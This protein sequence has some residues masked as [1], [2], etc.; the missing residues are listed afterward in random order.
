MVLHRFDL[1]RLRTPIHNRDA[2]QVVDLVLPDRGLLSF[3]VVN[4]FLPVQ[5]PVL[6]RD[7]PKPAND[8]SQA[9]QAQAPLL[10]F[11]GA[12]GFEDL[13]VEGDGRTDSLLVDQDDPV[14]DPDLRGRDAVPDVGVQGLAKLAD[15]GGDE[16][17]NVGDRNGDLVEDGMGGK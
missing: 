15:D 10:A 3:A 12:A 14:Q 17:V 7:L 9:G 5:V 16:I 1:S 13:W 4:H 11:V 8:Q 6:D 2:V